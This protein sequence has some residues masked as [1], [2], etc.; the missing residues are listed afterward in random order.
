MNKIVSLLENAETQ[1]ILQENQPL[2]EQAVKD[3]GNWYTFLN[4]YVSENI[5]EF[6]ESDLTETSKSIYTFSTFATKQ[7]LCE[8]SSY[9]GKQMHTAQVLKESAKNEFC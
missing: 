2:V 8:L 9:Y 3:L 7:Y 1:S 6:L 5:E 4:N